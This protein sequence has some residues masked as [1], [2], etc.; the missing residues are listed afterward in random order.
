MVDVSRPEAPRANRR[1][2]PRAVLGMVMLSFDGQAAPPSMLE[3][4]RSAPAAGVTLYRWRN[5]GPPAA[6][7]ALTASLVEAAGGPLLVAAD[8]EGGQLDTFGDGVTVF[9]G[10][11]ALGATG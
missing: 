9:P 1:A 3:R 6:V 4:L 11:M 5:A 7:R 2:D 10:A 8:Q